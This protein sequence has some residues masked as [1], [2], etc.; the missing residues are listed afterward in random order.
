MP[1]VSIWW[2]NIHPVYISLLSS[3]QLFTWFPSHFQVQRHQEMQGCDKAVR[4]NVDVPFDDGGGRMYTLWRQQKR[5][6]L[7]IPG[8]HSPPHSR[9]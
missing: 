3:M 5:E 4:Y 9:P 6:E 1:S 2:P 8:L 7:Q